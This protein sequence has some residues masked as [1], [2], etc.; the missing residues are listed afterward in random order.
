MN[1]RSHPHVTPSTGSLAICDGLDDLARLIR[2]LG[3]LYVR[4]SAGP[5]ADACEQSRDGESGLPLPGL[6]VN[7]LN[8]EP[9]WTRP[10]EHWL[11]R[12]LMQYGHLDDDGDFAWALAGRE[13]A[14]GPDSE[15]LLVE[16]VPVAFFTEGA[17]DEADRVYSD[18]FD[19]GTRRAPGRGLS[20]SA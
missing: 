7:P 5:D 10:I 8:P 4:Y 9:W 18:A 19:R 16:V 6:S 17:L 15:P 20:S 14:R 2:T 13:V 12:Q 1:P 11:A 3:P